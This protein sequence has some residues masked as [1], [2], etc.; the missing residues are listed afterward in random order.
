M[1]RHRVT[2][3]TSR[4]QVQRRIRNRRRLWRILTAIAVLA[5]V[6][7]AVWLVG[8]SSVFETRAATV[9]GQQRL[10]E[11]EIQEA[12]EVPVGL[13]LARV[14]LAAVESRVSELAPVREVSVSRDWP[15]GIHIEVIEREPVFAL[16]TKD[17]HGPLWLVD[18]SGIAFFEVAKPPKGLLTAKAANRE[19]VLSDLATVVTALT[20]ELV[21]QTK[22]IEAPTQDGIRLTLDDGISVVW[23]SAEDSALKVE[24]LTALMA[25][26]D[27][28]VYDVSAPGH[29]TTR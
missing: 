10:T 4:L 23:G 13:P 18:E 7:G 8:F 3:A 16:Q 22:S 21:K 2:D 14:D 9:S 27:A 28:D 12:A 15:H 11:A 19:E 5:V 25:N 6:G 29:P 17:S 1:A 20:P 24:V 26:V